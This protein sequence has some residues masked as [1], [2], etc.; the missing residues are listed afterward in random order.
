MP[1]ISII[2][3]IYKS[4]KYLRECI[5]S[6]INQSF[7][8]WELLLIDDGSPDK[9]GLICDEYAESDKR[10]HSF[11]KING[12]VSSA[13]NFGLKYIK[14]KWVMFIDSDD[15]LYSDAFRTLLECAETEDLDFVQSSF[16]RIYQENQYGNIEIQ[17]CTADEY[18]KSNQIITTVWGSIFKSDIIIKNKIMF[19]PHIKLG[20]DQLF[21]FEYLLHIRYARRLKDI[22][23]FYRNNPSS[24]INNPKPEYEKESI[25]AFKKLKEYNPLA[26]EQCDYMLLYWFI[27][28]A[29]N[30]K[31]PA[32]DIIELYK[33]VYLSSSKP[34]SSKAEII[35]YKLYNINLPFTIYSIRFIYKIKTLWQKLV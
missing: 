21:L 8:D 4:E 1:K 30:I 29:I 31:V 9:S 20:E 26:K 33:D 16:N 10:I 13:R 11:H 32:I 15:C 6:I 19:N 24:A 12:G 3:P 25:K 5:N 35:I 28:L 2:I 7:D 23:Y 18:V 14:G 17:K 34:N 27:S 22:L